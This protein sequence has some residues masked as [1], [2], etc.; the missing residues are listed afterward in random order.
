MKHIFAFAIAGFTCAFFSG[1]L[2]DSTT[3]RVVYF[4]PI[5]EVKATVREAMKSA[6]AQP[7]KDPGKLFVKDNYIYLN[8][9]DKGIHI[10]DYS[11][12]ANPK[13]VAFV[14]IPGNVDIAV[15]GNYLYADEYED[16]LTLDITNPLNVK[17]I[18]TDPNAFPERYV[19][20]P[21][22][23]I[24]GWTKVDTTM[25]VDEHYQT[26]PEYFYTSNYAAAANAT[27]PNKAGIAGSMARFALLNSRLYTVSL[28]GLNV[29]NISNAADPSFVTETSVGGGIE[30]IY[31]FENN[32][33]IGSSNGMYIYDAT[34][35]DNPVQTGTFFHT[36]SCDPVIA[37]GK[38]AFVTL[39]SGNVCN[40]VLNE[41]DVLDVTNPAN[42]TLLKT[43][44]FTNPRGLSKDG[45]TLFICDGTDGLKL[46]NAENPLNITSIKTVSGFEA[47]DVITTNNI[48]IVS[49]KD[50]L[51]LVDYTNPA[52]AFIKGKFLIQ[53]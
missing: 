22:Y 29:F 51:Y 48:A 14:S 9:V 35:P 26:Y 43:Y 8:E 31:P 41:L 24:I 44:Q 49:A 23:V 27:S 40:S 50:G 18:N 34:N 19:G 12:P 28:H 5:Y 11:D 4:K 25:K 47:Y 13:N 38:N 21:Q 33:F 45:N 32:L 20:G 37:D 16:L 1:C 6:P 42:S 30:T 15:S 10:L 46:L 17:L 36:T 52:N 3:K 2:K 39:R 7:I 53:Q